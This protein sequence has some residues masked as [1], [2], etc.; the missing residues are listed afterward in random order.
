MHISKL[1]LVNYRNFSRAKLF[2]KKGV[3]TI[4]GENGAG[5]SNVF[6]AIRLLLDDNMVRQAHKLDESD[7]HR[8]IGSWKGHWIILSVEFEEISPDEALQALF[9]HG[10]GIGEAGIV[11]R[12]SYNLIFRPKKHIR[13]ELAALT[14]HDLAGMNRI[15]QRL[16]IDDYETCFTG[17]SEADFSDEAVYERIVGNFQQAIFNNEVEFPEIGARIPGILSVAKEVSFTFIQ[18]LRDVVSEF[19]N[20]R[21]N[22]LLILL[23]NKSGQI[24]PTQFQPI[25]NHVRS[26]N[27]SIENLNDVQIVRNDIRDTIHGAAGQT[28][29]PSSLSIRSDLPDQADQL[30]QSLKL[31]V[32]ESNDA[33]EGSIQELSLGGAN[34]IFLTLKLLEFKYQRERQALANFLLIEEPE[35][36]LHT[37][38]QKTLFDRIGY[39]DAQIIYSTHSTHISEVS[40]VKS[41]NILGRDGPA[42]EAYQPSHGL[43]EQEVGNVQRYLDAVRSNL[44]F[45]KSVLLVEGDAEEI[46]IPLMIKKVLGVSLDELGISLINIR[47]TGFK[48]VS[49]L[50]HDDRI[51]R[52]CSIVT[53]LDAAYI[54]ITPIATDDAEMLKLKGKLLGAQVSG[55]ARKVDLDATSVANRWIKPFYANHT[56]EIDFVAA[57]NA[58]QVV[59]AVDDVYTNVATRALAVIELRSP[60]IALFGKRVLSMAT[61][62]GKGWFAILIGNKIDWQTII[63]AYIRNAIIFAHGNFSKELLF[64]I[65]SHR[66]SFYSPVGVGLTPALQAY[67]LRLNLYRDGTIDFNTIRAE[68]LVAMAGDRVC[69]FLNDMP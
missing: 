37:H 55:A 2:F 36:H 56:F 11:G 14:R 45:S 22:P 1:T 33:H 9:I 57:G 63:P 54:N 64:N 41:M 25:I 46:L 4:I 10:T 12:A 3:N 13:L 38:V 26:L 51:R 32:G 7:F 43:T 68:T 23:K 15:L 30:F 35:A 18:A 6:R 42:C 24:D 48:N 49:V 53:D 66:I 5:K 17:R 8:G 67:W 20:N 62:E 28:Y 50:F 58:E 47:S 44:L 19:H 31:F 60:D 29:S 39:A 40:K 61:Y 16:T 52:R 59:S 69:D 65:L 21:T 27:D 34:L